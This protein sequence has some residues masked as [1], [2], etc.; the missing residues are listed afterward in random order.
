MLSSVAERVYWA[1]RYLERVENTARLIKVY[2]NLMLDMPQDLDISWYNLISL[3]SYTEGFNEH[4]KVQNERNVLKFLLADTHNPSSLVSAL[5]A[6]R[7][8]IRTC[9]DVMPVEMWEQVNELYLEVK[10]NVQNGINRKHRHEFLDFVIRSCQQLTGLLTDTMSMDAA[11]H[12][13]RLGR[14]LERADMTTRILDAG[15]TEL[16]AS[17]PEAVTNKEQLVWGNVLSSLSAYIPYRKATRTSVNGEDVIRF[18]LEDDFFPRSLAFCLRQM[19]S[20]VENLPRH[21]KV[22]KQIKQVRK[23]SITNLNYEK[24]DEAFRDYLND[25]Q[26]AFAN[27]HWIYCETWFPE[28]IQQQAQQQ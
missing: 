9:R 1:A 7:E 24:L 12:F 28:V 25:V 15:A 17:D 4:Y 14:N 19:E 18:L 3:N 21:E 23:K 20:A 6:L 27:L 2:S 10:N 11:W 5:R 26:I 13:L 16:L 8:N 22:L